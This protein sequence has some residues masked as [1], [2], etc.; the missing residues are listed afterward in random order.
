MGAGAQPG[1]SPAGA[2]PNTQ[3]NQKQQARRKGPRPK[4][5]PQRMCV[6]CREHSAK[7]TLIRLV[8]TPEGTAEVDPTGKRNGRGAY[9]CD[10]PECW[11]KALK[12]GLLSRALN[13][14][15]SQDN[16]NA[17][18][19]H[20]TTLAAPESVPASSPGEGT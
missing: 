14:T 10:R 18:R 15:L 5:V 4:H 9:L 19:Q 2:A 13:I 1:A 6:A 16:I 20:A 11:E 17:L 7:R 12:T 8:R 3:S